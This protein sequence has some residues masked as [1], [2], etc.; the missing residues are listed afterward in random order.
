MFIF[1]TVILGAFIGWA[2]SL[3]MRTDTSEGILIDIAVAS[4]GALPMASLL[5]NNSTFDSLVAGGLG[6]L[7][8]LGLLF[9]VRRRLDRVH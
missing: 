9:L 8:A 4:L 7:C 6:A 3:L 2:W 1:W 5:G